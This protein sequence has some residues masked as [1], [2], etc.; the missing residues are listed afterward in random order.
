MPPAAPQTTKITPDGDEGRGQ[1]SRYKPR[2]TPNTRKE[3][4][5]VFTRVTSVSKSCASESSLQPHR[6][7]FWLAVCALAAAFEL[8]R[9]TRIH[10]EPRRQ[11]SQELVS[12]GAKAFPH[13]LLDSL[14]PGLLRERQRKG[15]T[16]VVGLRH[17][18][19]NSSVYSVCSVVNCGS[20]SRRHLSLCS[21][22]PRW[23]S[24]L[25]GGSWSWCRRSSSSP[26]PA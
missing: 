25:N 22:C 21:R 10:K 11:G 3:E 17:P 2:N 20:Y 5:R 9:G 7:A 8:A 1:R 6:T 12:A 16:R 23:H 14:L 18:L 4:G 15:M 19:A 24:W 13:V 26:S